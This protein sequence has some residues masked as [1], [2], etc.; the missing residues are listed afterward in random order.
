MILLLLRKI[1]FCSTDLGSVILNAGAQVPC[2]STQ[3]S[4]VSFIMLIFNFI[5]SQMCKMDKGINS[6]GETYSV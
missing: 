1:S 4:V 2:G 6:D 5:N 3:A